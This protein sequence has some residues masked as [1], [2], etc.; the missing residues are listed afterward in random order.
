MLFFVGCI[1]T[2]ITPNG[3]ELTINCIGDNLTAG[4]GSDSINYPQYLKL[5]LPY[6]VI[7]NN[8]ILGQTA[9]QIAARQ[10]GLPIYVTLSGNAFAG[11]TGVPLTNLNSSILGNTVSNLFLSSP[12]TNS[13]YTTNGTLAGIPCTITRSAVGSVP[14]SSEL[15]TI[16]PLA[17]TNAF[18]EANTRFVPNDGKSESNCVSILW[19]GRNN[20]GLQI[21]SDSSLLGVNDLITDCIQYNKANKYLVL[22]ILNAKTDSIGTATYDEIQI[23]NTN[24]ANM[25]PSNYVQMTPPTMD[26]MN[27][28]S[29][30][31]SATDLLDISKGI[32]PRGMRADNVN[33]NSMG[34]HIIANRVFQKLK[35]LNY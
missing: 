30:T 35:A 1:K 8:G 34:Y 23:T 16:K 14:S 22:G 20:V 10:G 33:L 32:F 13:T 29:Y 15:Y 11:L 26:E 31:P 28:I 6:R 17:S 5:L 12:L 2:N 9:E 24:S 25:Y 3:N 18:V 19:L 4:T 27:A 7:N 21:D